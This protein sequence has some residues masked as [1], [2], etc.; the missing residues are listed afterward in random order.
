MI[1]RAG[2]VASGR[3]GGEAPYSLFDETDDLPIDMDVL[4]RLVADILRQELQGALGER[5]T[6][7][8]RKL[9][10]AEIRRAL[11]EDDEP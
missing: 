10:R 7:N 5:V 6:R 1:Q 11:A 4:R 2:R 9:V 3:R 8:V